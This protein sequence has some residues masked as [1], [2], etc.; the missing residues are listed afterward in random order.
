MHER[1]LNLTD[2]WKEKS[3]VGIF[4][5]AHLNSSKPA[6]FASFPILKL[7]ALCLFAVS[8]PFYSMCWLLPSHHILQHIALAHGTVISIGWGM[9]AVSDIHI[10]PIVASIGGSTGPG[11]LIHS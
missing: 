8:L 2:V 7:Q 4:T 1:D 9:L 3:E 11:P 6:A 5:S 10:D